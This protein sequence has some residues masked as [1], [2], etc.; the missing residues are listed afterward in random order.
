MFC[1]T[2]VNMEDTIVDGEMGNIVMLNETDIPGASLNDKAPSE[3][4][5]VQLKRWLACCGAAVSR[6]SQS[7]LKGECME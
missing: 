5:V 7:L 3:L 1:V 4:N 2:L 6:K